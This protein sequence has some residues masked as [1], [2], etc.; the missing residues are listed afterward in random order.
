MNVD[1]GGL[2]D[3]SAEELEETAFFVDFLPKTLKTGAMFMMSGYT[4][5]HI[6]DKYCVVVNFSD[7]KENELPSA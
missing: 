4:I 6:K 2:E 5:M 7:E 3:L 1:L